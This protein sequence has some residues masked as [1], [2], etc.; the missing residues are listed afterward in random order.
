MSSNRVT[1]DEVDI[2]LREGEKLAL[3]WRRRVLLRARIPAS[4]RWWQR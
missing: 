2:L 3:S 4:A 1:A